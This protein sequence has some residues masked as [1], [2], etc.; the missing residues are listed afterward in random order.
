MFPAAVFSRDV[1]SDV[2]PGLVAVF[3][4]PGAPAGSL[5]LAHQHRE[6]L[7]GVADID[8]AEAHHRQAARGRVEG[9][10]PELLGRHLAQP[11]EARHRPAAFLQAVLAQ[12]V[13]DVPQ[14]A[15]VEAVELAQRLLAT[16][17]HV[18]TVERRPGDEDVA[19][20]DQGREMPEE[21]R[22]QQHLDV[23]AVD[24]GIRQDADLAVAQSGEVGP[25]ATC[26][27]IDTDR[28]GDVMDLVVGKEPVALGLPG[29]EQLAAQRQ[30]GLAFLVTTHLGRAAGRIALDEEQLVAGH[31]GGFAV[32]E[33]ARQHGHPRA[34]ALLD[35]LG[36]ALA[37]LC[38]AD[39][40]L[41][42][43]PGKVDV[44]VSFRNL[45]NK[46]ILKIV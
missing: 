7:L 46:E 18:D 29:V 4:Q 27:R 23:R 42:Q 38:L 10:L 28:H 33:L 31:V 24:I 14:L 1:R 41:G 13:L 6:A 8:A 9:G 12:L 15:V 19:G 45:K 37:G 43:L 17:R 16:R 2:G 21:Q 34:L 40:Q 44:N 35:L 22:Q 5:A 36:R 39:H 30:H 20:I 3:F 26:M 25:A 11:L 32:G